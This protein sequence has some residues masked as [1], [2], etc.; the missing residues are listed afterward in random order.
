MCGCV[1]QDSR[2]SKKYCAQFAQCSGN[3]ACSGKRVNSPAKD[4]GMVICIRYFAKIKLS[5]RAIIYRL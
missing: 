4:A 5:Y 3:S 2:D 1:K